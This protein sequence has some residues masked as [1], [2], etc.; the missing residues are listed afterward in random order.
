M[1]DEL[2]ELVE[3]FRIARLADWSGEIVLVPK[4]EC[5]FGWQRRLVSSR[6]ADQIA[7]DGNDSL[8]AFRPEHSHDVCR[9]RTPVKAGHDSR[10]DFEGIHQSNHVEGD[11]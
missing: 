6:A 4:Q 2:I 8:A 3:V 9:A 7:T 11:C 10:L 5:G 1:P